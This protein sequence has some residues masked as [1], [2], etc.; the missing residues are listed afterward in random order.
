M[1]CRQ[2]C[3]YY[4]DSEVILAD[5]ENK[6]TS[7]QVG[8]K[9]ELPPVAPGL[10]SLE[11]LDQIIINDDPEAI[12]NLEDLRSS[13][14]L[15]SQ[16]IEVFQYDELL[17]QQKRKNKILQKIQ[18]KFAL[19]IT[20]LKNRFLDFIQ[21]ATSK[22]KQLRSGS[23]EFR[24]SFRQRVLT[25]TWKE[26]SLFISLL[27]LTSSLIA[28]TYFGFVKK[29]L[30]QKEE[31]FIASLESIADKSWEL[32][33]NEMNEFFYNTVRIPKNI[34]NLRRI[35]VNVRPSESSS[36]NPM[37]A[38]ELSLEA[39][40]REALVEIKDREGEILD[41]VQRGLEELSYDEISGSGGR[42]SVVEKVRNRINSILTL[43]KIRHVYI[44]GSI[45]KP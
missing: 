6:S 32:N 17:E 24:K 29:S 2:S 22:A 33:P 37:V 11:Q 27:L 18:F 13:P 14:E 43:G 28:F 10:M 15:N 30:F 16:T 34:F 20:W 39:T 36:E 4:V 9:I 5:A 19:F 23:T 44:V 45:F 7:T 3:F 40:S 26:K 25:W 1:K 8:Q 41:T 31:L 21:L 35:V 12:K 38:L 42:D